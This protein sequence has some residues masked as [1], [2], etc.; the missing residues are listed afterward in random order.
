MFIACN[1]DGERVAGDDAN[2]GDRYFCQQCNQ[3]VVVK[4][5]RINI[6]HFAHFPG[7]PPC[8]WWEPESEKHLAMKERIMQLLTRD[9]AVI[10][11]EFEYKLT[12]KS[13]AL[14]PDVYVELV[15]G[16]RIAIECQISSKSLQ[17]FVW[18]TLSYSDMSVYTLWLF[19][20]DNY[21][22]MAFMDTETRIS[23]IRLRSHYWNYG[24]IYVLDGDGPLRSVHFSGVQRTNYYMGGGY[25][26]KKTKYVDIKNL[27]T[28]RVLCIGRE[29][30]IK[31]ARF[32]D[33]KW[34]SND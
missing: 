4:K 29:D 14:Y 28:T 27:N 2:K 34:W 24:R 15:D 20:D 25:Y 12:H 5:G 31:I 21:A 9:N 16:T 32:T 22:H 13:Y 18:K 19:P 23:D 33:K 11:A 3:Q 30:N 10:L 6:H 17:D 7:S 26:L 1:V 8:V